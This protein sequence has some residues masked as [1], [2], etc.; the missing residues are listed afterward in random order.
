M[1]QPLDE[2][3]GFEMKVPK[4]TVHIENWSREQHW[5]KGPILTGNVQDHPNFPKGAFVYTSTILSED[6]EFVETRNTL[7]VLGKPRTK[8]AESVLAHADA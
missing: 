1:D 2:E 8:P 5:L 7:Y 6:E 4:P 3:R